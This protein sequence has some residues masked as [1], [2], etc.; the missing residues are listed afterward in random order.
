MPGSK[1]A[2]RQ[3]RGDLISPKPVQGRSRQGGS[4][5]QSLQRR[6]GAIEADSLNGEIVAL[7]QRY[8][9]A[10]PINLLLQRTAA[11]MAQNGEQPG[12]RRAAD[13]LVQ[14]GR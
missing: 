11:A 8:G 7:G 6:T 9:V 4:T 13:L 3:R 12:G 2:A 5:W 10:T 1:T 14:A